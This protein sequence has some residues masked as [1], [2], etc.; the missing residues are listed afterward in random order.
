MMNIVEF[1]TKMPYHVFSTLAQWAPSIF[2]LDASIRDLQKDDPSFDGLAQNHR[3]DFF[4]HLHCTSL[5]L[6]L[7]NVYQISNIWCVIH[8]NL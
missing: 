6:E 1:S 4:F 5:M 8:M 3:Y 7:S 2:A